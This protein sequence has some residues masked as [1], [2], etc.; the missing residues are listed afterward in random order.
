[1]N[2]ITAGGSGRRRALLIATSEYSEKSLDNL[3]AAK[4]DLIALDAVFGDPQIGNFKI[5]SL[6]NVTKEAAERQIEQIFKIDAQA[7]DFLILYITGHGVLDD[8]QSLWFALKDYRKDSHRSSALEA[9]WIRN[10]LEVSRSNRQLIII[11]TCF[12]SMFVGSKAAPTID[13]A[14]VDQVRRA[15]DEIITRA[16]RK[17]AFRYYIFACGEDENAYAARKNTGRD[18]LSQLTAAVVSSLT[19]GSGRDGSPAISLDDLWSKI[20]ERS[21]TWSDQEPRREI[22]MGGRT[23]DTI[24]AW[25]QLADEPAGSRAIEPKIQL[26]RKTKRIRRR[27]FRQRHSRSLIALMCSVLLALCGA[28]AYWLTS[29]PE[30]VI[31]TNLTAKD[32]QWID[33]DGSASFSSKPGG[34]LQVA[35]PTGHL[36]WYGLYYSNPKSCDYTLRLDARHLSEKTP[37]NNAGWGYGLSVRSMWNSSNSTGAGW[38]MQDEFSYRNKTLY[39][40]VRITDLSNVNLAPYAAFAVLPNFGWNHWVINVKGATIK[41]TRDGQVIGTFPVNTPCGGIFFRVWAE[42]VQFRNITVTTG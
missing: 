30:P 17:N 21:S 24:L 11:D 23:N 33:T 42:T 36:Q 14:H 20:E 4:N 37:A 2:E 29:R 25:R 38:T 19:D 8:G 16:D 15:Q 32:L 10:I 35:V 13:S 6:L 18:Q 7:D 41:V 28:S 22:G 40:D 39:G 12:S 9:R 34:V 5:T 31:T 27:L 1:M 3:P 26:K